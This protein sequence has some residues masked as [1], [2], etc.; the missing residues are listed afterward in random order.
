[1]SA[2]TC[3]SSSPMENVVVTVTLSGMQPQI[4]SYYVPGIPRKLLHAGVDDSSV[5][6]E[7]AG[8]T[9]SYNVDDF[10]L[11]LSTPIA[12]VLAFSY[13]GTSFTPSL[14]SVDFIKNLLKDIFLQGNAGFCICFTGQA[15][16]QLLKCS[17]ISK[18]I[19]FM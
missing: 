6:Y 14:I 11:S 8:I 5:T 15:P 3:A 16:Q 7:F 10:I 9:G 12:Q 2:D 19:F 4:L 18:G 1:M 13:K 17:C